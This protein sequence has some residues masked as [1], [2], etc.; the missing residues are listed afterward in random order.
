MEYRHPLRYDYFSIKS[1]RRVHIGRVDGR[2]QFERIN[3]TGCDQAYDIKWVILQ[4]SR[5]SDD[6]WEVSTVIIEDNEWQ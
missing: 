1:C 4:G 6:D 3:N 2:H 5:V